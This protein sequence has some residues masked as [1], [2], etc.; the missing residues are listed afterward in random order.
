MATRDA[1]DAALP[2]VGCRFH[3]NSPQGGQHGRRSRESSG[4][5][6]FG[7]INA[8]TAFGGLEI[9][10]G[11][12]V[13][14]AHCVSS[15]ARPVAATLGPPTHP[16]RCR[17][18]GDVVDEQVDPDPHSVARE[19]AVR[20]GCFA[21]L[22]SVAPP[23]A[24]SDFILMSHERRCQYGAPLRYNRRYSGEASKIA[25]S[26]LTSAGM[27]VGPIQGIP[28]RLHS[29]RTCTSDVLSR[30]ASGI[31]ASRR[32]IHPLPFGI[33]RRTEHVRPQVVSTYARGDLDRDATI[34]WHRSTSLPFTDGSRSNSKDFSQ[35]LLRPGCPNSSIYGC[36]GVHEPGY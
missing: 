7:P 35:T 13:H 11:D 14:G 24:R 4:P 16:G 26:S 30:K 21:P 27:E 8:R 1:E 28:C 6:D 31:E 29:A 34:G 5:N 10:N 32:T 9:G 12:D 19:R 23:D 3:T 33:R 18:D 2:A 22:G 15:G 17:C 25:A 20:A 36:N